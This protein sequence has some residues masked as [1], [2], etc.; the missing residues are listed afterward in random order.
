MEK[1]YQSPKRHFQDITEGRV[2]GWCTGKKSLEYNCINS[3]K[4]ICLRKIKEEG[5][6]FIWYKWKA[7]IHIPFKRAQLTGEFCRLHLDSF[8]HSL[9]PL[10]QRNEKNQ[11]LYTPKTEKFSWFWPARAGFFFFFLSIKIN[12]KKFLKEGTKG[13]LYNRY[14]RYQIKFEMNDS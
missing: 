13:K 11:R 6:S 4:L 8:E 7:V 14:A 1:R 2:G 10:Y 3:Y 12:F 9:Y 5:A